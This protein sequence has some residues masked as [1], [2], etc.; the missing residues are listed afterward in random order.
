MLSDF[1]WAEEQHTSWVIAPWWLSV[2]PWRICITL[3]WP[4]SSLKLTAPS[5]R[6]ECHLPFAS[7]DT[8]S[9][10]SL[11]GAIIVVLQLNSW[12]SSIYLYLRI[13]SFLRLGLTKVSQATAGKTLGIVPSKYPS[14]IHRIMLDSVSVT[15]CKL[16]SFACQLSSFVESTSFIKNEWLD[17]KLCST[18]LRERP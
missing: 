16:C 7:L 13:F 4:R 17:T 12:M 6:S 18:L 1:H 10:Q 3:F 14:I 9:F 2:S 15:F 11:D 5:S 8:W